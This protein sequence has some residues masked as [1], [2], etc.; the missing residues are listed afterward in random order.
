MWPVWGG[1]WNEEGWYKEGDLS[2]AGVGERFLWG[3]EFD[4]RP[5]LLPKWAFTSP[6][7][8]KMPAPSEAVT[9]GQR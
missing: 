6:E 3:H 8:P 7:L 4:L 2:S 5:I 1:G 9:P